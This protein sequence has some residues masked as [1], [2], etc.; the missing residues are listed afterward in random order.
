M[1][2]PFVGQ[3]RRLALERL[4]ADFAVVSSSR[5]PRLVF[6]EAPLGWGKTRIVQELYAHLA[7]QQVQAYWPPSLV[8]D[9]PIHHVEEVLK[10]RKRL[11]PA[12]FTVPRHVVPDWV[13]LGISIDASVI[14]TP[15]T[16]YASLLSQLQ[17][18]VYPVL[19][20]QRMTGAAAR[21]LL[22]TAGGLLPIPSEIGAV[23]DLADG[24]LEVFEEWRSGGGKTRTIGQGAIDS[25]AALWKLLRAVW[26]PDGTGG[27]PI[28]VMIEDAQYMS[29]S[30][31]EMIGSV[32]AS[33]YPILLIATGWPL[34]EGERYR[35][36]HDFVEAK[37]PGLRVERLDELDPADAREIILTLHPGTQEGV[38]DLLLARFGTNPYALQ[39]FLRNRDAETGKP[40]RIDDLPELDDYDSS[41]HAELRLLLDRYPPRARRAV[42]IASLLGYRVPVQ[43]GDAATMAHTPDLS[44]SEALHTDW[45]RPDRVDDDI[46]AFVEPIRHETAVKTAVTAMNAA[47]R[48]A[49]IGAALGRLTTLLLDDFD[50][51][52]RALLESLY[53]ELGVVT[54]D[55]DENLFAECICALLSPAW[56]QRAHQRGMWLLSLIDEQV[57]TDELTPVVRAKVAAEYARRFRLFVSLASVRRLELTERALELAREVADEAPEILVLALLERSRARSAKDLPGFDLGEANELM[58]EAGVVAEQVPS[59]SA[60][61]AHSL[62]A[63]RYALVS[64][65]GDRMAA[66]ELALA[67]A[68]RC[69]QVPELR[70]Y[71]RS[72]SLSDAAFYMARVDPVRSF[73]PSRAY[74]DCLVELYGTATH[75]RVAGAEKDLAV[76][77]LRSYREDLVDEAYGLADRSLRMLVASQGEIHR[78]SL[79]ALISRGHA[80]RRR[81]QTAWFAGDHD[82][83]RDLTALALADVRRAAEG[84]RR[85]HG[86]SEDTITTRTHLALVQ[87]WDGERG[88]V[89][90]VHECLTYRR[91]T[92]KESAGHAEVLWLARDLR[93]AMMRHQMAR[94]AERIVREYPAAFSAPYPA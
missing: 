70:G 14:G 40:V 52:D 56:T 43:M 26:G 25:S 38:L 90:R 76:R 3:L 46:L 83:S 65:G 42:L 53:V 72:E 77:M 58:D 30:T 85:L 23:L 27:P 17:E 28:I 94:R 21:A 68:A 44:V 66:Y 91:E 64:A 20:R 31:V 67:E 54:G 47:Q 16:A 6:L 78:T 60:A 87:A 18:H 36:F 29:E 15:E 11:A 7:A 92:L 69:A 84:R 89:D 12:T 2:T 74:I 55:R 19:R 81:A 80:A 62:R 48:R 33:Q 1:N 49:L 8:D 51:P 9:T 88:A 35:P 32:L 5:T 13:W 63:R 50:D 79:A 93:D 10:R 61:L 75:P 86:R 37:P 41:V 34:V 73:P 59:L 82:H 22:S 24:A 45:M 57:R 39:L 71:S 4:I